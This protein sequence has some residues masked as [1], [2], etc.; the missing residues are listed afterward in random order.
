MKIYTALV[1]VALFSAAPALVSCRA[2]SGHEKADSTAMH[3]DELNAAVAAAKAKIHASAASLAA[4]V[5]Q[6]EHDPATPFAQY[7]KDVAAVEGAAEQCKANLQ[8]LQS[9]G[10]TY[11]AEWEKQAAT[12]TDP[13]LKRIA[14][15]RRAKL[16]QAIEAVAAAMQTAAAELSPYRTQLKDMDTYLSN[17]L[18]PAGIHSVSDRSKRMSKEAD[19]ICEK[20]DAVAEAVAK[21]APQ[22]KTAKP[23]PPPPPEAEAKK[24]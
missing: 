5:E 7:K 10:Q 18:T 15:E 11:V 4:V 24:G 23:P 16:A 8:A 2:S 6:A 13:E 21:N 1:L 22:F 12:I 14:D 19:S 3:M 17:D 9:Q 20:L